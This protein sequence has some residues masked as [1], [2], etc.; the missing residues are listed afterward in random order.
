MNF[1]KTLFYLLRPYM[2]Y[3]IVSPKTLFY[4]LRPFLNF[5]I[6]YP[7][8]LF[9]SLR[10]YMN[11]RIVYPKTVLYLSRPYIGKQTTEQ[12]PH[13]VSMQFPHFLARTQCCSVRHHVE[14]QVF[15]RLCLRWLQ[16]SDKVS[17]FG[18][19]RPGCKKWQEDG[20]G[21]PDEHSH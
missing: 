13:S 1:W 15:V 7:K 2:N 17:V 10:P 16:S 21:C 5:W 11:Y 6:V 9:Y 18:R 4:L 20:T 12:A 3:R 19:N 8:T 14:A